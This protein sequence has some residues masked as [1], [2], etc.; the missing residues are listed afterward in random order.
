MVIKL[1]KINMETENEI[2][3]WLKNLNKYLAR[4]NGA[5]LVV[6]P[7]RKKRMAALIDLI[8]AIKKQGRRVALL[9]NF[10]NSK[11]PGVAQ[12]KI[13]PKIGYDLED[14][15]AEFIKRG[16]KVIAA[17]E[18]YQPKIVK[19]LLDSA[20]VGHL[21]VATMPFQSA[22]EILKY[23]EYAKIDPFLISAGVNVII[24]TTEKENKILEI[25]QKM[26]KEIYR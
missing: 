21:I 1:K 16:F 12:I 24:E 10:S 17:N 26:A 6:G 5:I 23:L 13:N 22:K 8:L 9:E 7:D 20:L 11:L 14:I 3:G 15:L 2:A 18:V 4:S 25:D 19:K